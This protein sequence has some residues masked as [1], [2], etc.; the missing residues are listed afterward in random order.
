MELELIELAPTQLNR[1]WD[2]LIENH[3]EFETLCSNDEKMQNADTWLLE[4]QAVVEELICRAV[5]YQE[6]KIDS[7]GSELNAPIAAEKSKQADQSDIAS[8]TS[9]GDKSSKVTSVGLKRCKE[10]GSKLRRT[11][12][13]SS[14]KRAKA[15]AREA[16]LAKLKVEQL[17]EK[18]QLEA[19]IAAQNVQLDA[20]STIKEA[21]QEADR[22]EK[23][24]LLLREEIDED[25][26]V[27][28]FKD[29]E[30]D[31]SVA[32]RSDKI[33]IVKPMTQTKKST[34][35]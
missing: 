20:Q 2:Q 14:G 24:A 18:A 23:E 8:V 32:E 34:P 1:A 6:D 11:T 35:L 25:D 31:A 27:E 15:A 19:K 5:D 22:K 10:S 17:K 7:G 33:K 29:F 13:S 4:S 3:K 9:V 26:I 28:Y 16:D 30:D 21:K 12:S